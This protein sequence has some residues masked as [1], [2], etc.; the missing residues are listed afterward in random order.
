MQTAFRSLARWPRAA[1]HVSTRWQKA[2]PQYSARSEFVDPSILFGKRRE[3][4]DE[5]HPARR[6]RAWHR[7][8][9]RARIAQVVG[10]L[11]GN[12]GA[13]LTVRENRAVIRLD[14][15]AAGVM[16]WEMCRRI[17]VGWQTTGAVLK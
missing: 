14:P 10:S 9:R 4:I 1:R 11:R 17:K 5:S 12:P 3:R 7:P 13:K 6:I 2:R 16:L 8:N 15:P